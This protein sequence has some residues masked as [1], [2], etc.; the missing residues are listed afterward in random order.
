[1]H[2]FDKNKKLLGIGEITCTCNN[3]C[4]IGEITVLVIMIEYRGDN[5][6]YIY[7]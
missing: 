2:N 7:D 6:T 4:I 3:D 1:M 5:C